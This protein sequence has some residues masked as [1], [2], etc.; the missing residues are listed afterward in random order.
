MREAPINW[1]RLSKDGDSNVCV[2]GEGVKMIKVEEMN[3][4]GIEP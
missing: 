1:F 4:D 3:R 2:L